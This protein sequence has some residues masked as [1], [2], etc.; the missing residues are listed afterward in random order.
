[1]VMLAVMAPRVPATAAKGS[2]RRRRDMAE[3]ELPRRAGKWLSRAARG[4]VSKPVNELGASVVIKG[5]KA[6]GPLL[7]PVDESVHVTTFSDDA[8]L[9][10]DPSDI[11]TRHHLQRD[12]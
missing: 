5:S 1:M 6:A 3:I 4:T 11:A 2:E 8:G 12:Q 10:L 9:A 7:D